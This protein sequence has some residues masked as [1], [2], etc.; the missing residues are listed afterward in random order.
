MRFA[1]KTPNAGGISYLFCWHE[2]DDGIFLSCVYTRLED[3]CGRVIVAPFT[4]T[5]VSACALSDRRHNVRFSDR[6]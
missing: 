3:V 6:A 5:P 2:H 1:D 4:W